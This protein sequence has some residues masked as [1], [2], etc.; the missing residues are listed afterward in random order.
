MGNLARA[1]FEA[2]SEGIWPFSFDTCVHP[3]NATDCEGSQ[4]RAQRISACDATPGH[5][6][7]PLQGRGSPEIDIIEAMPGSVKL[8]QLER[9]LPCQRRATRAAPW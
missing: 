7:N 1:T 9:T 3:D 8:R 5:G 4:C 6:L 2:S